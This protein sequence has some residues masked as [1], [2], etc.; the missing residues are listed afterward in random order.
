MVQWKIS[1]Y[2]EWLNI[3]KFV[4][5]AIIFIKLGENHQGHFSFANHSHSNSPVRTILH[6]HGWGFLSFSPPSQMRQL[7]LWGC[8]V[9]QVQSCR[10]L[11]GEKAKQKR[12]KYANIKK[13]GLSSKACKKCGYIKSILNPLMP[14]SSSSTLQKY[15]APFQILVVEAAVFV[16][17]VSSGDNW[18]WGG[19][20]ALSMVFWVRWMN[21]WIFFKQNLLRELRH[22][23]CIFLVS[24]NFKN[25]H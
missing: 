10:S 5:I 7:K 6:S 25:I 3:S 13:E 2:F 4:N 19:W 1:K 17:S 8:S 12:L 14:A 21:V 22:F 16:L 11:F 24:I 18:R 23:F 9:K 15:I 20:F